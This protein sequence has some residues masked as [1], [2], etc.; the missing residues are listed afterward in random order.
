M[1]SSIA[2]W[3]RTGR[4]RAQPLPDSHDDHQY[5]VGN[6]VSIYLGA[7]G[8][9]V[10]TVSA[11]ASGAHAIGEAMRWIQKGDADVVIAGGA[12][13]CITELGYA[14]F[15]NMTALCMDSNEKSVTKGSLVPSTRLVR[16]LSWEKARGS[17]CWS[18]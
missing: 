14:G 4:D 11:C 16:V 9:N 17:W 10:S 13:A 7:R 2:A 5:G 12:E 6:V 3:W 8:P 18:L 15:C 1:E